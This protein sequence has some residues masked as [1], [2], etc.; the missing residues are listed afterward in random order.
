[1]RGFF[2]YVLEVTGIIL[3]LIRTLVQSVQILT[4]IDRCL[5]ILRHDIL[6]FAHLS[7]DTLKAVITLLGHEWCFVGWLGSR[8]PC[9]M[10]DEIR[11]E[12]SWGHGLSIEGDETASH[13]KEEIST[14]K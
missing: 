10:R 4:A 3:K 7:F 5:H 14:P 8:H 1:M 6:N 12:L 2:E 13:K 11:K 9:K